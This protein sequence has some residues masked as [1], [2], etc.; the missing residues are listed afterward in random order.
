M[1]AESAVQIRRV[2]EYGETL[3]EAR[4]AAYPHVAVYEPTEERAR[5]VLAEVLDD[6]RKLKRDIGKPPPAD[7]R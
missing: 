1:S 5:V 4:C 6:L 3:F 2:V 7:E